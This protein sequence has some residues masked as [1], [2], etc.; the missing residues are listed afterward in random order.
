MKMTLKNLRLP[1]IAILMMIINLNNPESAAQTSR[2]WL[3]ETSEQIVGPQNLS[4]LPGWKAEI[5]YWRK[6][7][8]AKLDYK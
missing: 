4:E 3:T 6:V 8:K 2:V 1:A 7:E 5:E